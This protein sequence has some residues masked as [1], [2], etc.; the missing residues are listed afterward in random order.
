MNAQEAD[1]ADRYSYDETDGDP[2][3]KKNHLDLV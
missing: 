2:F 1:G 3:D